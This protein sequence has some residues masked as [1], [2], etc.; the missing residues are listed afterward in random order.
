ML[1][2]R[3]YRTTSLLEG[4]SSSLTS[5]SSSLASA[6]LRRDSAFLVGRARA[7]G[8]VL[9][10]PSTVILTERASAV[11]TFLRGGPSGGSSSPSA[12]SESSGIVVGEV[13]LRR[14]VRVLLLG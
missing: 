7:R 11:G 9:A 8:S 12:E 10:A 2:P 6:L 13:V 5:S 3:S 4:W 1:L 14:R